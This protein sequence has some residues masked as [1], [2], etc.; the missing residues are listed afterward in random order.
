[1]DKKEIKIYQNHL[2]KH[3][4]IEDITGLTLLGAMGIGI[5]YGAYYVTGCMLCDETSELITKM[6]DSFRGPVFPL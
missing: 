4:K 2:K 6:I 5:V 3:Q 1:M